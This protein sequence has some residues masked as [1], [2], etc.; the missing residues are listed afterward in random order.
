M[1]SGRA[2][3]CTDRSIANAVKQAPLYT[4]FELTLTS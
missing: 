4:K 3:L 1:K 2:S